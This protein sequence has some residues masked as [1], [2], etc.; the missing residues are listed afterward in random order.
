[1]AGA[2]YGDKEPETHGGGGDKAYYAED[3]N[4]VPDGRSVGVEKKSGS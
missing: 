4:F 2:G 1:M 3:G